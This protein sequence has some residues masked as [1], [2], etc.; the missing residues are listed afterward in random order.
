MSVSLRAFLRTIF[1]LTKL[2]FTLLNTLRDKSV[3][4]KSVYRFD[5]TRM[6]AALEI[7]TSL[8]EPIA[9]PTSAAVRAYRECEWL[10]IA[11]RMLPDLRERR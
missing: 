11:W 1:I 8:P 6:N 3:K 4:V 5:D 7:A 9:I 10:V 2:N